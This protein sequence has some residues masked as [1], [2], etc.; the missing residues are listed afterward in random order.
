MTLIAWMLIG[1]IAGSFAGLA[2]KSRGLVSLAYIV[3]A[4]V[5]SSLSSL[6]ARFVL[7]AAFLDG[8]NLIT[9]IQL[10]FGALLL[11][12]VLHL[13]PSKRRA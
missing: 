3:A 13:I 2:I 7:G 1:L 6:L 10:V 9:I 12:V 5:V 11:I 8:L 4:L